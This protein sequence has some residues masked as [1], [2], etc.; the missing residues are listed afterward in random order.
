MY[1][2]YRYVYVDMN[3]FEISLKDS[4]CLWPINLYLL[5]IH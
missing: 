1:L 5:A 3:L 4:K 2:I